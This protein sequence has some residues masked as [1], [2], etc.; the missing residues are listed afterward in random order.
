M[1]RAASQRI[2]E[3][4]PACEVD[5]SAGG[6]PTTRVSERRVAARCDWRLPQEPQ[7]SPSPD[8]RR[9]HVG[10]PEVKR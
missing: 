5:R 10:L 6:D 1:V 4:A 9:T 3:R 7:C 2:L 8:A